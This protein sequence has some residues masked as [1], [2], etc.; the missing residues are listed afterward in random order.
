MIHEFQ[1]VHAALRDFALGLPGA[2]EEFPWG[3]SVVKVNKKV[4]VFLGK[5]DAA[6][7]CGFSVKL[8]SSR[9]AALAQPFTEPTGYGLGKS[10]WVTAR[11]APGD[12][13][14]LDL[15]L[16]WVEESYRA[17][18]PKKMVAELDGS[19]GIARKARG[20]PEASARGGAS[21]RTR[22]S[23]S[24][25]SAAEPARGT[26]APSR[27]GREKV[28]RAK[29]E[30]STSARA[31]PARSKPGR[32]STARSKPRAKSPPASDP[33]RGRSQRERG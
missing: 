3:E 29:D 9:D 7:D 8:P 14:T 20:A 25:A 5:S 23:E 15:L 26:T 12:R 11:F 2:T 4:F 18:A 21:G 19:R 17:V 16:A 33:R 10:G 6:E 24:W 31:K 22:R 28:A 1:R 13:P 27:A 32:S 30:R